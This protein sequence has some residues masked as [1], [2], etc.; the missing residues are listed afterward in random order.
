MCLLVK[1][2]LRDTAGSPERARWLHLARSDN[3]SQ[4]AI[5]FILPARRASHII[6]E[7][8]TP[9]SLQFGSG[10]SAQFIQQRV[11][12]QPHSTIRGVYL[13]VMHQSIPAVPMFPRANPK[14]KHFFKKKWANSPGWGH[15]SC[16][17]APGWGR[18]KRANTPPLV[19]SP[20]NTVDFY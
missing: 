2:C 19:S 16:L 13:A 20:S 11:S 3:Q 1:F 12:G 17:N 8:I 15:I 6:N 7:D 4:R 14:H 5:W 9:R 18:R 10:A